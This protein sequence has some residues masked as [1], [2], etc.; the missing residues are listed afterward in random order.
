V[1]DSP[2]LIPAVEELTGLRVEPLIC[3]PSLIGEALSR[4]Y[5][6]RSNPA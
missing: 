5:P 3:P 6:P 4:F 1:A 2:R